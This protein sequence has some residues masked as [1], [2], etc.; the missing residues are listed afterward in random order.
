M[1]IEARLSWETELFRQGLV[2]RDREKMTNPFRNEE[3]KR[4]EETQQTYASFWKTIIG[5]KIRWVAGVGRITTEGVDFASIP[6]ENKDN[7][8]NVKVHFL[9]Y[10]EGLGTPMSVRRRL[11]AQRELHIHI[12]EY[13]LM[14]IYGH[15]ITVDRIKPLAPGDQLLI[16]GMIDSVGDEVDRSHLVSPSNNL[17]LNVITL[18]VILPADKQAMHGWSDGDRFRGNLRELPLISPTH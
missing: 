15:N 9:P 18:Y 14:W 7:L 10:P 16:E 8:I 3:L 2:A 6:I 13:K 12:H 4:L 5:K 11:T 17:I 1:E